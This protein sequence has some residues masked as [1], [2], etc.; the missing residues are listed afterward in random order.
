MK[1]GEF[2]SPPPLDL[3][4]HYKLLGVDLIDK[5]NITRMVKI[6]YTGELLVQEKRETSSFVMDKSYYI[7]V[8]APYVKIT[9]GITTKEYN[10]VFMFTYPK[11]NIVYNISYKENL[12]QKE[13]M[14]EDL[15]SDKE[16]LDYYL[17]L[18]LDEKIPIENIQINNM[19]A[20][21]YKLAEEMKMLD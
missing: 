5:I 8:K 3:Q 17:K 11:K 16:T 7:D 18:L 10:Y 15:L 19:D 2:N 12:S 13:I 6:S 14:E 21:S 1:K 20:L 9:L 4:L